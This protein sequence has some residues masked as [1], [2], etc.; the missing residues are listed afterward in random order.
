V[1]C[2]LTIL[3]ILIF[4]TYSGDTWWGSRIRDAWLV[5]WLYAA[6]SHLLP[7]SLRNGGQ[8]SAPP[9]VAG[10]STGPVT[11]NWPYAPP[12][13]AHNNVAGFSANT[14]VALGLCL[15]AQY[16]LS[17]GIR[18]AQFIKID[19]VH[20]HAYVVQL[21]VSPYLIAHDDSPDAPTRSSSRLFEDGKPLG[22][23][24]SP[25]ETIRQQ[26][27]GLFSHRGSELAF[28]TRDGSDPRQ[29]GRTYVFETQYFLAGPYRHLTNLGVAIVF[30]TLLLTGRRETSVRIAWAGVLARIGS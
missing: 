25:Q 8:D 10:G 11:T 22:P 5:A 24:H 2:A 4:G 28:S 18:I 3:A 20:G 1:L 26:G 12:G 19:Q 23:A 27:G 6:L 15:A 30:I 7:S 9:V 29:N 16:L 21:P 17:Q 14:W 13:P